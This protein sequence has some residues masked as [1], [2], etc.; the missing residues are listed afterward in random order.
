MH[1]I[2][3]QGYLEVS[4]LTTLICLNYNYALPQILSLILV[5][6]FICFTSGSGRKI[7]LAFSLLVMAL[8][9]WDGSLVLF[10]YFVMTVW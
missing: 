4:L 1:I 8:S 7:G 3:R 6:L 9:D 2:V 5:E 10:L